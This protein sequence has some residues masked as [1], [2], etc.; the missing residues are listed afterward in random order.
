MPARRFKESAVGWSVVSSIRRNPAD[1]EAGFVKGD[2]ALDWGFRGKSPCHRHLRQ[3]GPA[4][5]NAPRPF[6]PILR[7]AAI[8]RLASIER[9]P[10][11]SIAIP[12]QIKQKPPQASRVAARYG[13][14]TLLLA[15]APVATA[16]S[17]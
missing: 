10:R 11:F 16:N 14:G 9:A 1:C 3:A 12:R 17:R 6:E 2:P 8:S 4:K 7:S 13:T 5:P 15:H